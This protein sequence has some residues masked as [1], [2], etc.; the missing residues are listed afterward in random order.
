[1]LDLRSFTLIKPYFGPF[2]SILTLLTF[3]SRNCRNLHQNYD[4]D[5]SFTLY[6]LQE[7]FPFYIIYSKIET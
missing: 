6:P 2:R 5:E 1:M 4:K 3:K 7:G